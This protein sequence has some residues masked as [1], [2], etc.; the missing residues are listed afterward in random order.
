MAKKKRITRKELLK[1]PDEIYIHSSR[2]F[3]Y[4]LEHKT[5]FAYGLGAV[6]AVLIIVAGIRFF[7]HRAEK[8]ATALLDQG[9]AKYAAEVK[10]KGPVKAHTEVEK[11]F[12]RIL[13]KYSKKDAGKLARLIYAN[14]CYKAGKADK[15]IS[16]YKRSLKDFEDDPFLQTL[17]LS[18]LGYSHEEKKEY[19]TAVGY[20]DRIASSQSASLKD[21]ALFNLG[22]LYAQLG[23]VQKS[24]DAFQK[25]IT[26]HPDSMYIEMIKEQI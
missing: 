2:L 5:Q 18:G 22:R 20:F 10:S 11:E 26:D 4:I 21:E 23:N 1:E 25:I 13:D 19:E 9:V 8:K 17:I 7:S 12:E 15:A 16:L 3:R 24:K 14:I 6:F